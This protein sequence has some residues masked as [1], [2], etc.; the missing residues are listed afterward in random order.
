MENVQPQEN[1]KRPSGGASQRLHQ[2]AYQPGPASKRRCREEWVAAGRGGTQG[3][4]GGDGGGGHLVGLGNRGTSREPR[5]SRRVRRCS[6]GRPAARASTGGVWGGPA[7]GGVWGATA[8]GG[9]WGGG[10]YRGGLG[11]VAGP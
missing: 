5:I 6:A 3:G 11:G 10:R 7:T 8:A 9:V 4:T 1:R 2:E